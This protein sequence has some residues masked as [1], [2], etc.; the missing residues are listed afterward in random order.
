MNS[1]DSE[2]LQREREFITNRAQTNTAEF[3]STNNLSY[4][5][6]KGQSLSNTG[7][8]PPVSD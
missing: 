7:V 3:L 1:P 4:K 5:Y 8:I 2:T 6:R